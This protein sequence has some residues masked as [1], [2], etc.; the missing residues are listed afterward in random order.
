MSCYPEHTE[1]KLLKAVYSLYLNSLNTTDIM[2]R[3]ALDHDVQF[4]EDDI[5]EIIDYINSLYV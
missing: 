3:I 4:T 2:L 5:D 1:P